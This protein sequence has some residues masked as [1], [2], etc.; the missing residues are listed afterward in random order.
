MIAYSIMLQRII[1][2]KISARILDLSYWY[3]WLYFLLCVCVCVCVCVCQMA[4]DFLFSCYYRNDLRQI[5]ICNMEFGQYVW[6]SRTNTP[7]F[8]PSF[9]VL[10]DCC[11]CRIIIK[12]MKTLT[13]NEI[14][15]YSTDQR[16]RLRKLAAK[17]IHRSIFIN[18]SIVHAR[19][20]QTWFVFSS[21]G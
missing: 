17:N 15:R 21:D 9:F 12:E 20:N 19:L 13:L 2:E 5:C 8:I 7:D 10:E 16:N 18:P 3:P 6:R 4:I 11:A 1:F 14:D